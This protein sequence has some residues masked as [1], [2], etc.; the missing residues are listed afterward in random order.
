MSTKKLLYVQRGKPWKQKIPTWS[1]Q[2]TGL[3]RKNPSN[4]Q[5]QESCKNCAYIFWQKIP[6]WSVQFTGTLKKAWAK[7][8]NWNRKIVRILLRTNQSSKAKKY[9]MPKT[10]KFKGRHLETKRLKKTCKIVLR[11]T[12]TLRVSQVLFHSLL[13]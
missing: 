3:A 2:F 13:P 9:A 10:S 5:V 6:T 8:N 11:M 4:F 12:S 1:V 7:T